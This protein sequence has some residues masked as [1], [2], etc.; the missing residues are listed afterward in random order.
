MVCLPYI[1][2]PTGLGDQGEPLGLVD[3]SVIL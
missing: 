1:H 2:K 3:Y